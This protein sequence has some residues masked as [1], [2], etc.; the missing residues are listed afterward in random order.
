M[1]TL[2]IDLANESPSQGWRQTEREGFAKRVEADGVLALALVHHLT[3]GKNIPLVEVID[4]LLS[5]APNGVVE[6][7]QPDDMQVKRLLMFKPDLQK[8]YNEEV[9]LE[10]IQRRVRILKKTHLPKSRRLLVSYSK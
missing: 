7:P 9:F 4:W 5:F 8:E 3:I 1:H 6:F 10:A 2:V